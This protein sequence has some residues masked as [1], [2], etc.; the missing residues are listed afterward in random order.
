MAISLVVAME[1]SSNKGK[2]KRLVRKFEK[3]RFPVKAGAGRILQSIDAAY[4]D[5]L[6]WTLR[7]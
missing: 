4:Q 3:I 7:R 1:P 2:L 6:L 5:F